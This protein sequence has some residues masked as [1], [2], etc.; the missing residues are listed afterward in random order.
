MIKTELYDSDVRVCKANS[1]G[2]R[3]GKAVDDYE[4][5]FT[6]QLPVCES[7]KS[8]KERMSLSKWDTKFLVAKREETTRSHPEHGR[9]D[10]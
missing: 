10:S 7:T 8:L 6:M 2:A 1:T 4:I 5:Q 3:E 9:K